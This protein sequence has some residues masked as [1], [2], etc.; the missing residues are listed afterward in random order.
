MSGRRPF[1]ELTAHFTPEQNAQISQ[2]VQ[3]TLA[4]IERRQALAKEFQWEPQADYLG[5]QAE[6]AV[7]AVDQLGWSLRR[8]LEHNDSANPENPILQQAD[9]HAGQALTAL[10]QL[11]ELLDQVQD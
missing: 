3:E 5:A 9:E 10:R 4:E 6:S 2:K 11:Y 7:T 8:R 1:S